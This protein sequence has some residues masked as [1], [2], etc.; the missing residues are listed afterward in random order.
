MGAPRGVALTGVMGDGARLVVVVF[1]TGREVATAVVAV[2]FRVWKGATVEFITP[3]VS[4]TCGWVLRVLL[5][6]L[7][8]LEGEGTIS[9]RCT[10][11]G[12]GLVHPSL[13]ALLAL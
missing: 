2:P 8:L 7:L 13:G 11:L 3:L 6:L 10:V 5:L 12:S 4:T 9:I 1:A